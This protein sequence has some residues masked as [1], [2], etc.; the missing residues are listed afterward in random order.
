MSEVSLSTPFTLSS[1]SQAPEMA[2][3]LWDVL[4]HTGLTHLA[5][6]LVKH[7]VLNVQQVV[8]TTDTLIAD[9][10]A[11]WQ[12]ES[13][14]TT[15]SAPPTPPEVVGRRDF[16]VQYSG[17]RA[18]F[19]LAMEAGSS[20]NRKRSLAQLDADILARSTNPSQ[21]AR[22]RTYLCLCTV[23]EVRAFPLDFDN[24][25]AFA[26]SLKAGGYRSAA[27]YFQTI[28]SHQQRHLRTPVQPALRHCIRDCVRS[29]RRGLGVSRLKDSFNAL[30]LSRIPISE[31]T[32]KFDMTR[33]EHARDMAVISLWF[34]LREVEMSAAMINHLRLQQD[35]IT[36]LIPTYKTDSFGK[37]TERTL[38]C[39]CRIH[40]H[41]LC[42]WHAGERHLIRMHGHREPEGGRFSPLFPGPQGGASSKQGVVMAIRMVLRTAGI[43]LQR[44][45]G[46]GRLV[47]RFHG[48]C[49]RVS[50]AQMLA[51]AGV[52]LQLIQLLGRWTSLAVQRYTQEAAL[53]VTPDLTDHVLGGN[54]WSTMTD[55]ALRGSS[56]SS[57]AIATAGVEPP[58]LP[59]PQQGVDT[60]G[61][62][63]TQRDHQR[64]I[65]EMKRQ[66][67]QLQHT[68]AKPT[69]AFVKRV[70]SCIVHIGSL[71]EMSNAPQFWRS[72]C[73]WQYG[74]S[75]FLRVT[76]IV[77]PLRKCRKCFDLG[78]SSG[79]EGSSTSSSVVS[80]DTSSDDS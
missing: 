40:L 15:H 33:V 31:D 8:A 39:S 32:D 75:N 72:K 44:P 52:S 24:I 70:R 5:P 9:S 57:Q 30:L 13:I 35:H 2:D 49:L 73:G 1:L 76:D 38:R 14:I 43:S 62:E 28:C 7:G 68:V 27:V 48:H 34:M 69:N 71:H 60:S 74:S 37:L 21:D 19:S 3:T 61:L 59:A 20:N 16:P 46:Q 53:V 6:T 29:I 54:Q 4:R 63:S 67:A 17:R 25:R 77:L 23:W 11:Q 12:I 78:D 41:P 79:S 10:V 55:V 18:N 42:P 58:H 45:D 56:Q 50:G 51:A 65:E 26:A 22:L 47:E 80:D 64:L 36:I 66:L